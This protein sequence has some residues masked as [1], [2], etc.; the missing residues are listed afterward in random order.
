MQELKVYVYSVGDFNK[1]NKEELEEAVQE[2]KV[3]PVSVVLTR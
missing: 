2:L 1:M 3:Y